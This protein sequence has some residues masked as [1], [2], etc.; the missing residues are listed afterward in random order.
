M[1]LWDALGITAFGR[2]DIH[3]AY[4]SD[5]YV[6]GGQYVLLSAY[7]RRMI[8]ILAQMILV[9]SNAC[10]IDHLLYTCILWRLDCDLCS[11]LSNVC[12][13]GWTNL[14]LHRD[15]VSIHYMYSIQCMR[16]E[17]FHNLIGI[18]FFRFEGSNILSGAWYVW[19]NGCVFANFLSAFS[20]K[21]KLILKTTLWIIFSAS[22][23]WNRISFTCVTECILSMLWA[24][25][26]RLWVR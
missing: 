25:S 9:I 13:G 18:D 12:V 17:G 15:G 20:F 19:P 5:L 10:D 26:H 2:N 16:L 6:Y 1:C 23:T 21:K 8:P 3:T 4:K 7:M 22:K 11:F 14:C 24:R